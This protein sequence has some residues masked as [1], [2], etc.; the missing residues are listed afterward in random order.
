MMQTPLSQL[1][2]VPAAA[3]PVDHVLPHAL[4]HD[5]LFGF[6]VAAKGTDVPFLNIY[7]GRYSFFITNHMMMTAVSAVVVVLV[8][9]LVSRKVRLAGEGLDA[10]QTRGRIAQLFE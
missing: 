2:F 5:E 8:F 7:D 6:D 4:H 10:Y 3:N 9:W 1:M